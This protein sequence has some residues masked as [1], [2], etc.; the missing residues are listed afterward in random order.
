MTEA[1]VCKIKSEYILPEQE[2]R[3]NLNLISDKDKKD[4]LKTAS[5]PPIKKQRLS[6]KEKKKLSGQNKSRGPTFVHDPS[7]ELCDYLVQ[8]CEGEDIPL[9]QRENCKNLHDLEIYNSIRPQHLEG[10]WEVS[11]N[12]KWKEYNK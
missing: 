10:I 2:R 9:C 5:E 1:G 7:K 4:I 6:K 8:C 3:A 11:Y 12:R